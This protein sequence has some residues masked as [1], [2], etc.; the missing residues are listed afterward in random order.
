M[1]SSHY[2]GQV[3]VVMPS[4]SSISSTIHAMHTKKYSPKDP[5]PSWKIKGVRVLAGKEQLNNGRG[6]KSKAQSAQNEYGKWHFEL[7]QVW[8]R[9]GKMQNA[10][11][12]KYVWGKDC[13]RIAT[14]F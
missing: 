10:M 13:V 7:A 8:V 12:A 6:A 2:F 1:L 4:T 5:S 11:D 3:C 9:T 14:Q